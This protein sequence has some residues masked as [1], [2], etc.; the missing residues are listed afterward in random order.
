VDDLTLAKMIATH[1]HSGCFYGVLPYTHHLQDVEHVLRRF[2]VRP[3]GLTGI[4]NPDLFVAAWLHDIVEDTRM[5]QRE[6]E[7]TFGDKVTALVM[8][9][10]D[11]DGPNRAA[12][13]AL[14]YPKTRAAGKDAVRLKLADRI[15]N[16]ENGGRSFA[17]YVKEHEDFKRS[18]YTPGENEDMWKYLDDL[19]KGKI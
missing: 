18:L 5:K 14:T 7:E 12:R 10:T 13:K 16:M 11:V 15:A 3:D 17:M 19:V 8:A 2:D 1:R 4:T 6:L 9:V